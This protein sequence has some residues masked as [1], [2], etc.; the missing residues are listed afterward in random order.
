[1]IVG[2]KCRCLQTY[3]ILFARRHNYCPLYCVAVLFAVCG[4]TARSF[5]DGDGDLH[6]E[7]GG[8]EAEKGAHNG[9]TSLIQVDGKLNQVAVPDQ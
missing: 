5:C 8:G 4:A 7:G 9:N 1:M 3:V 2:R 6:A